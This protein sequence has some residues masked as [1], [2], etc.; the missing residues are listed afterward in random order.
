MASSMKVGG[1]PDDVVVRGFRKK[2]GLR[3]EECLI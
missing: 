3:G 1:L 2:T